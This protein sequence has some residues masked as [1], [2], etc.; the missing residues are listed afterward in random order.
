MRLMSA[1]EDGPVAAPIVAPRTR[2]AISD[3]PDQAI[4]VSATNTVAPTI[5]ST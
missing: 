4:A 5:P 1:S 3:G 2:K